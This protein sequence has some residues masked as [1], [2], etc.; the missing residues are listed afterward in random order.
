MRGRRGYTLIELLLVVAILAIAALLLVPSLVRRDTYAVEAALRR[1][2]ADITFAQSDALAGQ[3][4]RRVY[5][6]PEGRGWS[7]TRV[8][9]NALGLPFNE[10]TADY[11]RDPLASG[12]G[13]PMVVELDRDPRFAGVR[14]EA[15]ELDDSRNWITFDPLGGTIA[16]AGVPGT[17]GSL[18]VRSDNLTYRVEIDAFTGKVS[19]ARAEDPLGP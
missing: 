15:I 8:P 18:V 4:Y 10:E 12:A 16:E 3:G 13:Q 6:D 2:V 5:F 14:V 11:V 1:L 9:E 17:G 19:I 7:V